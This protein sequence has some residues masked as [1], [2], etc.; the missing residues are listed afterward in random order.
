MAAHEGCGLGERGFTDPVRSRSLGWVL[1]WPERRQLSR[2]PERS[3]GYPVGWSVVLDVDAEDPVVVGDSVF[4]C[5]CGQPDVA[6]G[7]DLDGAQAV[8]GALEVALGLDEVAVLV[9][10][11]AVD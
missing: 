7:V 11:H 3:W 4:V 6:L 10:A 1:G 9:D 8:E 5:C 2:P